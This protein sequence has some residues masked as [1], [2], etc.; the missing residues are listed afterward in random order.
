MRVP[1][2]PENGLGHRSATFHQA[3][4]S[5]DRAA[6]GGVSDRARSQVSH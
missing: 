4:I 6:L 3:P 5:P 2:D 1:Y